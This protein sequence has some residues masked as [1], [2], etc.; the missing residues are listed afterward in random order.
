[1]KLPR[2]RSVLR[3]ILAS[4]G[5]LPFLRRLL[6]RNAD[7]SEAASRSTPDSAG[8]SSDSTPLG[9]DGDNQQYLTD[10]V[11]QEKL[12]REQENFANYVDVHDLPPIFHYWSNKY[13][14]PELQPFGFTGPDSFYCL[15]LEAQLAK[16]GERIT[17]FAS[18]G[19][20]NC[21][22]E[23]RLAGIL[24]ERGHQSFT[25]ECLDINETMLARGTAIA[26]DAGVSQHIIANAIDFNFWEPTAEYDAVIANQSLHHVERLETLFAAIKRA[27]GANGVFITSDMIGRNG[28]MRW[29]EALDYVHQFWRELPESH[30]YN[31]QLRRYEALYEN[32]DCSTEGFEGVRAQDVLAL[33]VKNF[34]FEAFFAYANIIDPFIDRGFGHN[35][36]VNK[37]SDR[38]FI[39]RVHAT[40][41]AQML[42]GNIKPTQMLAAMRATPVTL[43]RFI[44]PFT[45]EFCVRRT[46]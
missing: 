8:E 2:A 9:V 19:A 1:M 4:I 42:A 22:T 6:G 36:D 15:H 21:D 7:G 30:R 28:H 38:S 14:L 37:E 40:D 33:L 46:D 34:H 31:H 25:I 39:D 13:L 27:I 16:A 12:T 41:V 11:Y 44:P 3:G 5:L 23:V 20:G 10:A 29:P 35:F 18:V 45:P 26:A 17:R 24:R 43:D 32:W